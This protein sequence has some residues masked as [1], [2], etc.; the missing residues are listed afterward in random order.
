MPNTTTFLD[1]QPLDFEVQL[2]V[3]NQTPSPQFQVAS[4][5]EIDGKL[6]GRK[7]QISIFYG[8]YR[9]SASF[10]GTC[11]VLLIG[12]DDGS[13]MFGLSYDMRRNERQKTK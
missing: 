5:Q 12:G 7:V 2:P 10:L 11:A 6:L 4:T 1:E 13:G 3:L 9:R 8:L